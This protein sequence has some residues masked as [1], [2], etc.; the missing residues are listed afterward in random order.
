MEHLLSP[1]HSFVEFLSHRVCVECRVI[2]KHVH[3]YLYSIFGGRVHHL[4]HLVAAAEICIAYL[5]V[6]GLIIIVPVAFSDL[7][8]E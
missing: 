3:D 4:F 6:S 1:P 8:V 2:G 5:P 7:L